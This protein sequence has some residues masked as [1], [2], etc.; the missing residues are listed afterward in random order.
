MSHVCI[1]IAKDCKNLY[2]SYGEICV[3]CNCCGR[4][5]PE[6]KLECQLELNKRMLDER[7]AF[8]GWSD[9]PDVSALQHKN[10]AIDIEYFTKK[11]KAIEAEI[12]ARKE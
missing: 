12:E 3:G 6:T 1:G 5:D 11:I 9:Y 8:D 2:E 7:K 10:V 4:F